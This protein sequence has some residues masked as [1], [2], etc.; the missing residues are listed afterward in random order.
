M[1]FYVDF[2]YHLC[3]LKCVGPSVS[4]SHR[5]FTILWHKIV[6]VEPRFTNVSHHEQIFRKKKVSGDERCLE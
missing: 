4:I 1:V 6:A 2:F 5:T 3:D